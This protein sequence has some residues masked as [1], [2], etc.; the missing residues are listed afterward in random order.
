MSILWFAFKVVSGALIGTYLYH[1]FLPSVAAV[2]YEAKRDSEDNHRKWDEYYADR[3][4]RIDEECRLKREAAKR[5][6]HFVH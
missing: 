1:G 6:E 3:A 4:R 2:W 5:G